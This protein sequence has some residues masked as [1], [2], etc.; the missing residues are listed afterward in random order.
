M[1][2]FFLREIRLQTR[3]KG[4]SGRGIAWILVTV[5]GTS[6]ALSAAKSTGSGRL[7]VS[8]KGGESILAGQSGENIGTLRGGTVVE[9][10]EQDGKWVRFRLE[11]WIW[12]PS[13]DGFEEEA[14]VEEEAVAAGTAEGGRAVS[15]ERRKPRAAL[16]KHLPAIKRTINDQYGVFYGISLDR[17][18]SEL[19]VRFRVPPISREAL[20]RRQLAVQREVAR[21]MAAER[22]GEGEDA[23]EVEFRSIRVETNR[24]DGSG[25]VGLEIAVTAAADIDSGDAGAVDAST[26]AEWKKSTRISS[27]RGQSWSR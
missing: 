19:V 9:I 16:Q 20:E 5:A 8:Q 10:L 14:L 2:M 21:I 11:G 12:G 26:V 1:A 4:L 17:E 3:L 27:D 22:E 24:P 15:R 25:E 13:L 18:L 7:A 6:L 23:A